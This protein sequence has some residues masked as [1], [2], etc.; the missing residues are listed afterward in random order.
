MGNGGE[1]RTEFVIEQKPR[2]RRGLGYLAVFLVLVFV[3]P[4]A[5]GASKA[6]LEP[7]DELEAFSSYNQLIGLLGPEPNYKYRTGCGVKTDDMDMDGGMPGGLMV[8]NSTA[9]P[10]GA[11]SGDS[12]RGHSE[13][14]VSVSGVD[15]GDIVKTDG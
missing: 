8:E 15:E 11:D 6:K 4:M 14:N 13:T 2:K 5:A 10:P 12:E 7:P 9:G 3:L 1:K